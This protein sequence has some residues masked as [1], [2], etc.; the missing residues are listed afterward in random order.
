MLGN[1]KKGKKHRVSRRKSLGQKL[2]IRENNN[3]DKEGGKEA[4]GG[5]R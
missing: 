5:R 2:P 3:V 1:G 4:K